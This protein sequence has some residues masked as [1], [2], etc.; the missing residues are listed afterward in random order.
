MTLDPK[1]GVGLLVVIAAAVL[2]GAEARSYT[3]NPRPRKTK[4]HKAP[5]K[6]ILRAIERYMRQPHA[7][8]PDQ[9]VVIDKHE[10]EG[11]WVVEV[12]TNWAIRWF[13][14]WAEADRAVSDAVRAYRDKEDA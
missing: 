6:T 7:S 8:R 14:T 12:D 5:P 4:Q 9:A 10:N 11:Y 3:S 1:I 2:V 13:R